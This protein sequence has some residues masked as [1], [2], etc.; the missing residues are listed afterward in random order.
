MPIMDEIY[1]PSDIIFAASN[2]SAT[3]PEQNTLT[4]YPVECTFRPYGCPMIFSF[5]IPNTKKNKSTMKDKLT[6][7]AGCQSN[8]NK[9]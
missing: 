8:P 3:D 1:F 5:T 9:K 4:S 2:R 6:H 7:E